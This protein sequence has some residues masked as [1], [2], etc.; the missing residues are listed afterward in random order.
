MVAFHPP[1]A[2][3]TAAVSG[4]AH[5]ELPRLTPHRAQSSSTLAG[6]PSR[7]TGVLHRP[8]RQET[9]RSSIRGGSSTSGHIP[10]ALHPE[11]GHSGEDCGLYCTGAGGRA[12]EAEERRSW[13]SL[14]STL[15]APCVC[16]PQRGLLVLTRLSCAARVVS[17][18]GVAPGSVPQRLCGAVLRSPCQQPL[19]ALVRRASARLSTAVR[20]R[21]PSKRRPLEGGEAE[22]GAHPL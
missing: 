15:G 16:S 1:P 8:R 6:A 21:A 20:P 10:S 13:R 22:R 3:T 7:D 9:L 17:E 5:P 2:P 14:H 18:E 12:E 19:T 4:P 11:R